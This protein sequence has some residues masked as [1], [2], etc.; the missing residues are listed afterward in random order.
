[1]QR[2]LQHSPYITWRNLPANNVSLSPSLCLSLSSLSLSLSLS[3][4]LA[5]CGSTAPFT[6]EEINRAKGICFTDRRSRRGSLIRWG[7][8]VYLHSLPVVPH[9]WLAL[10]FPERRD[11]AKHMAWRPSELLHTSLGHA[12]RC[13]R[14]SIVFFCQVVSTEGSRFTHK[15]PSHRF[16]RLLEA[17]RAVDTLCGSGSMTILR[18]KLGLQKRRSRHENPGRLQEQV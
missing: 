6:A 2:E 7:E 11:H 8:L 4:S 13:L 15:N 14:S 18:S 10:F 16:R 9:D 1:M 5:R 3:R 17:K 12:H